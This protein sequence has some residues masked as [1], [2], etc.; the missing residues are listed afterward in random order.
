[1]TIRRYETSPTTYSGEAQVVGSGEDDRGHY[2][3]FEQTLFYPQGG[4]QPA[5]Q[6]TIAG[7]QG[8]AEVGDVRCVEGQIRHYLRGLEGVLEAGDSII[9]SIVSARRQQ[10]AQYH[11]AG[12]LIAAVTALLDFGLTPVKGHHFPGEANITFEG[13]VPDRDALLATVQTK[14]NAHIAADGAVRCDIVPPEA[15]DALM[16]QTPYPLP[17]DKPIRVCHIEGFDS[18]PC[19]GTHISALGEIAGLTINKC[20]VKKGQTK[21]YYAVPHAERERSEFTQ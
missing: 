14:V 3:I 19:G 4:G 2:V 21:V 10:N 8:H 13:P 18:V 17:T 20:K 16:D 15:M 6:G 11:T 12:H 7:P 5:D 1:M 9:Q